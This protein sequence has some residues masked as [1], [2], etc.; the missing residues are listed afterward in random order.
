VAEADL[1]RYAE[2]GGS[3]GVP[4]GASWGLL[5][6]IGTISLLT[7][8]KVRDGVACVS[9]GTVFNLDWP[10]DAFDPPTS[11]TRRRPEH[12]IFQKRPTHRDDWLDSFYLQGSTQID[13]LRHQAHGK[14]G[15]YGGTPA[16]ELVEQGG[17]IGIDGFA[18]HGIVGRAV[19]LDVDRHLRRTRGHGLDHRAG[20]AFPITTL[21][22]TAADECVEIRR[23]DILLMRTG[24]TRHYFEVMTAAERERLP[25]ELVSTGLAQSEQALAWLWDTGV[26]LIAADNTSVEVVPPV[27]GPAFQAISPDGRLHPAAIAMLGLPFGELWR[28]DE[29]AEACAADGRYDMLVVASPLNLRGGVGSPANAVAIR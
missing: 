21:I 11:A 19:L 5:G 9:D 14:F 2:L 13:G 1:P 22:E 29:L 26:A 4:R 12:H 27:G 25:H 24:W 20:E 3:P 7:A 28:L 8:E 18:E 6:S 10:L 15:F 16:A 17:P 23:G